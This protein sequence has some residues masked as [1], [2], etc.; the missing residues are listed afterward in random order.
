MSSRL[1]VI[2][3]GIILISFSSS[4]FLDFS[5]PEQRRIRDTYNQPY[6]SRIHH[7]TENENLNTIRILEKI[8]DE[9]I[10]QYS[11]YLSPSGIRVGKCLKC[12]TYSFSTF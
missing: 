11:K 9:T 6:S 4:V 8:C 12:I 2:F 7:R 5:R 3:S 10:R 1:F